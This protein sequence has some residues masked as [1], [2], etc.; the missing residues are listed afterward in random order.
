MP[1]G[2][3]RFLL[4][5]FATFPKL[6]QNFLKEISQKGLTRGEICATIRVRRENL[7]PLIFRKGN[8]EM[9]VWE[10]MKK[11]GDYED[12][13]I[14]VDGVDVTA[15]V[16][17]SARN[18]YKHRDERESVLDAIELTAKRVD[19]EEMIIYCER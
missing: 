1:M 4:G 8:E 2:R 12:F 6:S 17:V 14:Y 5:D 16:A 15:D 13:Y 11:M 19:L 18:I 9:T 10:F 7:H 3:C